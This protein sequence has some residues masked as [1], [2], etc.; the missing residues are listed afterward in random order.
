[1]SNTYF[2]YTKTQV[3]KDRN[4]EDRSV[5]MELRLSAYSGPVGS[6]NCIQLSLQHKVDEYDHGYSYITLNVEE[7]DNLI[8]GI[9]ERRGWILFQ[10][11]DGE[12]DVEMEVVSGGDRISSTGNEQ[13]QIYPAEE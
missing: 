6:P 7:Q 2:K 3:D 11:E 4:N 1:M 12:N 9:L 10:L 13:S 5:N 8:A